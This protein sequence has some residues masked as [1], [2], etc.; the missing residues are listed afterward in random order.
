MD[1]KNENVAWFDTEFQL[2]IF[3][4]WTLLAH[5]E[6]YRDRMGGYCRGLGREYS[7]G[8]QSLPLTP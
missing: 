2:E 6:Y 4:L 3:Q 8:F 1:K 7:S 5:F